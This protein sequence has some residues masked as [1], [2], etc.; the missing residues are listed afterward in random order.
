[1]EC[2]Y[3]TPVFKGKSLNSSITF[4]PFNIIAN[5]TT[6]SFYYYYYQCHNAKPH[7]KNALKYF[8]LICPHLCYGFC[9]ILP[10]LGHHPSLL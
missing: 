5:D 1:M 10:N 7:T 9:E 6:N 3:K 4:L 8:P 2:I